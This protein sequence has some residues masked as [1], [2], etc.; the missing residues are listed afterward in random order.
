M[1]YLDATDPQLGFGDLAGDCYNGYARIISQKDS[2]AVQFDADSLRES[3]FTMVLVTPGA[4]GLSGSLQSTMGMQESLGIRRIVRKKGKEQF[5]K[6]IQTGYGDDATISNT[7]I[8]SLDQPEL[9]VKVRYDFVLKEPED[10]S[11][12]YFNPMMGD[13]KLYNPF[14]AA[15][16]KYPIEMPYTRDDTYVFSMP[17]PDGYAVEELPKSAKVAFNGDQ[18]YF[19]Y[20]IANQNGQIQMRCRLRMN[21]AWFPAEDYSSLRDFYGYVVRKESEQIVLKKK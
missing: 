2:G 20:L 15:E 17:V 10:A 11:M 16:R 1:Y 21:K 13:A 8:D 7:G 6:D 18:G 3:R 4:G 5:F 14:E 19:E 12:I 9:P